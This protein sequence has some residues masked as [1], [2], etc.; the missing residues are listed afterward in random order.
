MQSGVF[1]HQ[2]PADFLPREELVAEHLLPHQVKD[3]LFGGA[4]ATCEVN[5]NRQGEYENYV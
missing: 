2:C 1:Q 4:F 5:F 3:H